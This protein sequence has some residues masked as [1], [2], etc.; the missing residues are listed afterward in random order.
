MKKKSTVRMRSRGKGHDE[1]SH[2]GG[3][4]SAGAETRDTRKGIAEDLRAHGDDAA[5][6]VEEQEA[7]RPHGVFD[8]AAEGP[9]VNHVADDVHPAAVHEHGGEQG[10]EAMAVDDADGN[11]RPGAHKGVSVRELL[12][13]D[14]DVNEDDEDGDEAKA[15]R[16]A[17]GVAQGNEA[18]P[19]HSAFTQQD[20]DAVGDGA[21]DGADDGHFEAGGPPG[22]DGDQALGGADGKVGGQRDDGGGDDRAELRS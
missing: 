18:R 8:L 11:R 3:D 5:H 7:D 20:S 2:D 6:E 9:Q 22:A 1:R 16:A 15:A 19:L 10:D 12:K 17:G 21:F 13:E 4:G 14:E